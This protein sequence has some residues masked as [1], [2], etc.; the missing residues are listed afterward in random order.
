[1]GEKLYGLP[2]EI[3][4]RFYKKPGDILPYPGSEELF[5]GLCDMDFGTIPILNP[6]KLGIKGE[7]SENYLIVVSTEDSYLG[8]LCDEI[9][10]FREDSGAEI[11][12]IED[13]T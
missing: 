6:E 7:Y 11:L 13:L 2:A 10:G 3:V 5:I 9:E 12:Q 4:K 1:M 8:I